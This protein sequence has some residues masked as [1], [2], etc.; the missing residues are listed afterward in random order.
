VIKADPVVMVNARL[1]LLSD[2]DSKKK[3]TRNDSTTLID[4]DAHYTDS[5]IDLAGFGLRFITLRCSEADHEQLLSEQRHFQRMHGTKCSTDRIHACRVVP[6][7]AEMSILVMN[8]SKSLDDDAFPKGGSSRLR[9]RSANS[10]PK[11]K[12]K[13]TRQRRE[14]T[15][16]DDQRRNDMKKSKQDRKPRNPMRRSMDREAKTKNR[17]AIVNVIQIEYCLMDSRFFIQKL[18]SQ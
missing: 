11:F 5:R 16:K 8:E 15:I 2:C 1:A 10:K 3:L 12:S 13:R 7:S 17:G 9:G 4:T 14:T 18:G 6:E